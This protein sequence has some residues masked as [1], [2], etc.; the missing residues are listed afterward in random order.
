MILLKALEKISKILEQEEIGYMIV[1]G[2]AVSYYN[3]VRTTADI[4]MVL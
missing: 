3:R 1:G 2:F 4:D